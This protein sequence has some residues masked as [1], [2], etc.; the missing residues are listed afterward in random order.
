MRVGFRTVRFDETVRRRALDIGA[1][2]SKHKKGGLLADFRTI[3]LR[4]RSRFAR[5]VAKRIENLKGVSQCCVDRCYPGSIAIDG[6]FRSARNV[7]PGWLLEHSAIHLFI[8]LRHC[9]L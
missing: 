4:A 8:M 1:N 6:Q 7:A 3:T 9:T 2:A 5:H